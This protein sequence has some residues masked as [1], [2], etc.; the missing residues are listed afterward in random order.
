MISFLRWL[1]R[2]CR[3]RE[4]DLMAQLYDALTP[5]TLTHEDGKI[6]ITGASEVELGERIF[7]KDIHGMTVVLAA[8][9]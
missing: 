6:Y 3:R 4:A 2:D 5:V 8:D 9:A 7:R 1:H